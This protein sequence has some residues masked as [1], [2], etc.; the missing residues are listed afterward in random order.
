M[1]VEMFWVT[2]RCHPDHGSSGRLFYVVESHGGDERWT[3]RRGRQHP[4]GESKKAVFYVNGDR[5]YRTWGRANGPSLVPYYRT[6]GAKVDA[7]EGYPTGRSRSSH[8]STFGIRK[9]V[10]QRRSPRPTSL[11]TD[12]ASQ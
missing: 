7:D 1:A 8:T 6:R 10:D 12:A 4:D 3:V 2:G 5:V 11:V 9:E